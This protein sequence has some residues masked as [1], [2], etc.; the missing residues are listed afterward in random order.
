[1]RDLFV[2]LSTVA[3]VACDTLIGISGTL[4]LPGGGLAVIGFGCAVCILVV[5]RQ[6]I[7]VFALH[8][9]AFVYFAIRSLEIKSSDGWTGFI[10]VVLFINAL[11]ALVM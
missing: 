11:A 4:F 8:N 3:L 5:S 6:T 1:M 7:G 2:I 10:G 9:I